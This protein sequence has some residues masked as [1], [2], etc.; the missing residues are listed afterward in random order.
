VIACAP[1]WLRELGKAIAKAAG[2]AVLGA[3]AQYAVDAAVDRCLPE[4]PDEPRKPSRSTRR[5]RS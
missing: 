5:R 2:V 3:I 4:P 1:P